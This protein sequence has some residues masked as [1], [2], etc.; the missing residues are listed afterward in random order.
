V[1]VIG[2]AVRLADFEDL[3]SFWRD[4]LHAA[5]RVR[6]L[7]KNRTADARA[8]AELLGREAPARFREAA[9]L[10]DLDGFDPGRF[11]MAPMDA[12]L[13]DPEQRLFLETAVHALDDAGYGGTALDHRPIGVFVGNVPSALYR[14]AMGRRF[15]DRA[16]QIF[17]LNVPSNIATRLAFLKDWRGPAA[18]V[19]TACSSGLAAVHLACRAL[20]DGACEIA[21]VGA[22]KALPLPPDD[23]ARMAIDSSTARTHAFAA[24]ADGT[25][26]GE[27]AVALLLKPLARA[28]ADG[29]AIRAVILGSAI[30]Q[31]GA[32][33]G[34]AAP[35]PVAQAEVVRAAAATAGVSLA[36]LSYV[37]AHGTGTA[38]GDP[39]EIA[40]LSRAFAA[41]TAETGFAAI[42]SV[43]GNY[44]HLDA[45]AGVLGLAKAVLCLHHDTAPPQPFFDAANPKIDF[46]HAPVAVPRAATPLADRNGPRRAGVSSFGLSGINV[47]V[48]LEAA[49]PAPPA[50]SPTG[51]FVVG[52]SAADPERLRIAAAAL[53]ERCD[54]TLPPLPTSPAPWRRDAPICAA[55]SAS[56]S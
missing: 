49:P 27:G 23:G 55:A 50:P 51:W 2:R 13:L 26:M 46:A 30:N 8:F 53:A 28:L 48:V 18:A 15:P 22:A 47:H 3:D 4:I 45:A 43:K 54:G 32:S 42:G 9:Y 14:E 25:G 16:E 39:I 5:D 10:E 29:D 17:A 35:N 56:A 24:A 31:D 6:P 44:G 36:S 38:L 7:P 40:G 19:D 52:V 1:A 34:L 37:E 41:D 20:A 11:R 12:A 21:L 33:S